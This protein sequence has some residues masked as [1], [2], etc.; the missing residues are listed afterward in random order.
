MSKGKKAAADPVPRT[1]DHPFGVEGTP[2]SQPPQAVPSTE[3][4][5]TIAASLASGRKVDSGQAVALVEEAAAIWDAAVVEHR[6]RLPKTLTQKA[7]EARQQEVAAYHE[8][9]GLSSTSPNP[10]WLTEGTK[11]WPK[12]FPAPL[13]DFFRLIL[14]RRTEADNMGLFREFLVYYCRRLDS[15]NRLVP[16]EKTEMPSVEKIAGLMGDFKRDG[17]NQGHWDF[18][19]RLFLE[20]KE[21]KRSAQGRNAATARYR[22]VQE[23]VLHAKSGQI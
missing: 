12:S 8:K 15:M 21:L 2:A 14:S 7:I 17:F 6:R 18:F 4:L 1:D 23:K 22:K 13:S 19:G 20:F 3:I 5:A 9:M 10:V 11:L 16:F